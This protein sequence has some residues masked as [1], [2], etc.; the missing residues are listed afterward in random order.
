M[1]SQVNRNE[2]K[3]EIQATLAARR[4]LG[5]DYDE[6]FLD[7]LVEKLSRQSPVQRPQPARLPQRAN[8]LDSSQRLAL[9][10]CSLIFSI[11]LVA[12]AGSV[13]NGLSGLIGI[14]AVCGAV[15]GINFAASR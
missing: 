6:Q 4:E 2:G 5:P 13:G 14:I 15:L 12:I 10:I 8:M 1:A 9:A 3:H 7:A 11:P